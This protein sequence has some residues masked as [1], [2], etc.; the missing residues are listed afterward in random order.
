M[1]SSP[2][3][4]EQAGP[5]QPK[6]NLQQTADYR[7]QYAN[8]VQIRASVWDFKLVFGTVAVNGN[9]ASTSVEEL[10]MHNFQGIY[11]SPQQCKALWSM[12]GQN[13][14]HYEQTFGKLQLEPLVS[15]Q[16]LPPIPPPGGPVN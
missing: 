4:P 7:E 8:S 12:L 6:I 1:S 13:L 2:T 11:L 3:Q 15:G 16:P 10:T 5:T 9:D 14:A